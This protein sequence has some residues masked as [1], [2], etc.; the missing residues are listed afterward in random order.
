MS[1]ASLYGGTETC[2]RYTL[3]KIGIDVTFVDDP[4]AETVKAAI[5]D[6]TKAVYL[7]TI[8][9]PKLTIPDLA[10]IT[11]VAHAQGVPVI[12]DNTTASP[13]LCRPI[14]HGADIVVHSLTKYLGGHGNSIGGIIV[15]S[16]WFSQAVIPVVTFGPGDAYWAHR[17]DERVELEAIDAYCKTLAIFLGKWCGLA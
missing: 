8:G 5:R 11:E 4:T 7:E 13:A 10:G 16:G 15:D 6:N 17:I 1:S 2:F 14:E 3:P 12:V 9:N